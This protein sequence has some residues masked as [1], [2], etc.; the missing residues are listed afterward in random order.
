MNRATKTVVEDNFA[1]D[2]FYLNDNDIDSHPVFA[3]MAVA[4][5]TA[6]ANGTEPAVV[7]WDSAWPELEVDNDDYWNDLTEQNWA[8]LSRWYAISLGAD[9]KG[10]ILHIET[11]NGVETV[12]VIVPMPQPGMAMVEYALNY[13]RH[14]WHVFPCDPTDKRPLVP[15]GFYAATTAEDQLRKWWLKFPN[16]MIGV[17][18]GTTSGVWAVDPDASKD[19]SPDGVANWTKI[20]AK[21]GGIPTTHTHNTP[22]GGQHLLFKWHDDQHVTN[23]EGDLSGL[24][25]NVRGEGGYI[26][27]PP[28]VMADGRAYAIAQPLDFFHFAE[29]PPWLY[30]KI[31]PMPP[32][33]PQAQQTPSISQQAVATVRPPGGTHVAYADAA[34]RGEYDAVALAPPRS[35]NNQ[36]NTSTFKLGTLVGAGVLD[37]HTVEKAMIE[38]AAACGLVADDGRRK[39]LATI[40]SGLSAGIRSPRDITVR[41]TGDAFEA[42]PTNGTNVDSATDARNPRSPIGIPLVY[43]DDVDRFVEKPWLIKGVIAKGETSMWIAPPGKLKSALATDIGIH[44]A[45]GMDW[46]GYQSKE[47]CGVVYFALERADLVKRRLAAHR[48]RDDLTGLPIAVAGGIISLMDPKSVEI[49]IT[50]IRDAEKTFGCSVGFVVVDT[51]AKGIAAGGGDE[52]Q[53][54]DQGIAIANLRRVQEQTGV[55]IAIISHTGKDEK[56]GARGSNAQDGDVD[57]MVQISGDGIKVATVTKANDQAEGVLT[58]FKAEIAVLGTDEDG[59]EIMTAIISLDPCGSAD[60]KSNPKVPLKA[61]ERRA[62]DL[63]YAAV[64]D[65]GKDPPPSPEFPW[66][67]KVVPIATWRT[68][69]E[70]GGLSQGDTEGAF[71][72]AFKRVTISLANK[73]RIGMLDEWVWIAYDEPDPAG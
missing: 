44:L 10:Q 28:S 17:R 64:V 72:M 68:Y 53:A 15:T 24:G 55:H 21:F 65:H 3:A 7:A 40:R 37:E 12:T 9:R 18:M 62:M 43:F 51:Y 48:K 25:I 8:T 33:V 73:H 19:G 45:S 52:N 26:V 6:E 39:C 41:Q 22:N 66:K 5:E 16:A 30:D 59:G 57:V 36:L 69:C 20:A 61:T 11:R 67:I 4:R 49:I 71:R 50:T 38:A 46:R 58:K 60:A 35:R 54:K 2:A 27:V 56:K 32:A 47:P 23:K 42:S 13:A 14:G 31:L 63:L 70:R 34:L 1:E 29:A